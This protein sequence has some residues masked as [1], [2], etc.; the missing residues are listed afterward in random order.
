[1]AIGDDDDDVSYFNYLA[2]CHWTS[3]H[4]AGIAYDLDLIAGRTWIRTRP[5]QPIVQVFKHF[6]FLFFGFSCINLSPSPPSPPLFSFVSYPLRAAQSLLHSK[7]HHHQHPQPPLY[8]LPIS[9]HPLLP[10]NSVISNHKTLSHSL[11][12]LSL[13]V[14]PYY[15][16]F[17][18]PFKL[19]K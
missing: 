19:C 12:H 7:N 8:T 9:F 13:Q 16:V 18:N 14:I 1:M 11:R 10:T 4:I 5:N 3:C 17:N 6:L 15:L 2:S